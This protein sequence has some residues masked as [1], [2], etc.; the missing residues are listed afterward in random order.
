L[1]C[2]KKC[3]VHI[4]F[5]ARDLGGFGYLSLDVD[6]CGR[7]EMS[8]IVARSEEHLGSLSLKP[9]LG[10]R[11]LLEVKRGIPRAQGVYG[12]LARSISS[13]RQKRDASVSNFSRRLI[14]NGLLYSQYVSLSMCP[15][16]LQCLS[17]PKFSC[18]AGQPNSVLANIEMF[19]KQGEAKSRRNNF[20]IH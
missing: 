20:S 2:K 5:F 16:K 11:L 19:C 9:C 14:Q 4:F 17:R 1:C 3:K 12:A 10:T 13:T 6:N 18:V 7:R 8:F 15:T